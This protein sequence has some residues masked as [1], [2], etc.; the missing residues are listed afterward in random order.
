M[1][2]RRCRRSRDWCT[3]FFKLAQYNISILIGIFGQQRSDHPKFFGGTLK[4]L[5]LTP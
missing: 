3:A 4:S 1:P 2:S 5:N